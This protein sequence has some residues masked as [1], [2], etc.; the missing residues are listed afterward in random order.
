MRAYVA[1]A[2]EF[3]DSFAFF[4]LIMRAEAGQAE[5]EEEEEMEM[6]RE[7][8]QEMRSWHLATCSANSSRF[9][10]CLTVCLVIH[11]LSL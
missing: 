11:C 1:S 6:E 7:Q 3:V 10:N 4:V 2:L 9:F 8:E 5:A